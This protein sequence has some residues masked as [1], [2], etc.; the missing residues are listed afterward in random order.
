MG[1]SYF[2]FP[3]D[4][5]NALAFQNAQIYRVKSRLQGRHCLIALAPRE[6]VDL[7]FHADSKIAMKSVPYNSYLDVMNY[8]WRSIVDECDFLRKSPKL[9][10]WALRFVGRIHWAKAKFLK[11]L[12]PKLFHALPY[13]IRASGRQR[14]YLI[15]SGIY[16]K[17]KTAFRPS[18]LFSTG[19][20][21]DFYNDR[22]LKAHDER[23]NFQSSFKCLEFMITSKAML[24]KKEISSL[25]HEV[26]INLDSYK[27]ES[28]T[29]IENFI[30]TH[31][32]TIF[33]RTRNKKIATIHNPDAPELSYLVK[34]ILK[35]GIAVVNAGV[36]CMPLDIS[37][38]ENYLEISHE[39]PPIVAMDL[40]ANCQ[41]L[42]TSAGGD[43]FVGY[44]STEIELIL[45][46]REWS[47]DNLAESISILSAREGAGIID[48]NL[49]HLLGLKDL[50]SCVTEIIRFLDRQI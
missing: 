16:Y 44:A 23:S 4:E 12:S 3:F 20:Y 13:F 27:R 48:L 30:E 2:I 46:D 6:F 5:L 37:N 19:S 18:K 43:F 9:E 29:T 14:K 33:L 26:K 28:C 39:L 8:T 11:S 50:D 47:L 35:E 49:E 1:N 25:A 45:F 42:M 22:K 38:T 10:W 41:A 15:N 21:Y 32:R 31:P 40:A 34:K 17:Y 7:Y 24:T 36:P